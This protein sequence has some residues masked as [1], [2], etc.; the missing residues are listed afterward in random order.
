MVVGLVIGFT[1]M[2]ES[3]VEPSHGGGL[4]LCE[5]SRILVLG[6]RLRMRLLMCWL[7][8]VLLLLAHQRECADEC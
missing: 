7:A 6:W 5:K 3:Y 4:V 1:K 2:A 8:L